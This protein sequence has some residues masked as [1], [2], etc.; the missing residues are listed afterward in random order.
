KAASQQLN[1]IA[2]RNNY[3]G[4]DGTQNSSRREAAQQTLNKSTTQ[5]GKLSCQLYQRS[6]DVFLGL[7]FNIASYALLVHM[8]AQ[9]CDLDVG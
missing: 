8:M 7:P 6:C 2:Q 1:Q 4:Y 9:Q 3:R 5:H